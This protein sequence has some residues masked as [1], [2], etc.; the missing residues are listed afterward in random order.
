MKAIAVARQLCFCRRGSRIKNLALSDMSD[1]PRTLDQPLQDE[2]D[3]AD[4]M[5]PLDMEVLRRQQDWED[6]PS[7][8]I[9]V[10]SDID[11]YA[12][13]HPNTPDQIHVRREVS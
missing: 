7:M 6:S 9:I 11:E 8:R 4:S 13:V 2:R 12:H 10:D 3:P 1:W 5:S